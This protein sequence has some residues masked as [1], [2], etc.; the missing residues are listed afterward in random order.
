MILGLAPEM[1]APDPISYALD[2]DGADDLIQG[3]GPIDDFVHL[4]TR[5]GL[6][7]L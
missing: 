5:E 1:T 3:V 2:S 4:N 6:K 7:N